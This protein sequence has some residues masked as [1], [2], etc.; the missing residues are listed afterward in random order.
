MKFMHS[1]KKKIW[2]H[3]TKDTK[4]TSLYMSAST[5]D[6]NYLYIWHMWCSICQR[7]NTGPSSQLDM[8]YNLTLKKSKMTVASSGSETAHFPDHMN[9]P[10]SH[11]SI[12]LLALS[13]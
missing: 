7:Y 10:R 8:T 2:I 3:M 5:K 11:H 13:G 9:P 4:Q 12:V 6:H 1:N